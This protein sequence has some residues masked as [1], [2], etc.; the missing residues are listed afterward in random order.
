[1]GLCKY[2]AQ[3]PPLTDEDTD[4]S[5]PGYV[6]AGL[7]TSQDSPT[8]YPLVPTVGFTLWYLMSSGGLL[9]QKGHRRQA[10]PLLYLGRLK[11]TSRRAE[12]SLL[13]AAPS[14]PPRNGS[15][16]L[17]SQ[18]GCQGSGSLESMEK[19]GHL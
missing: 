1:M 3:L 5:F 13:A 2:G 9:E 16:R 19:V 8:H 15:V 7:A 11:P 4:P 6:S 12:D 17:S 18:L 14:T 10:G